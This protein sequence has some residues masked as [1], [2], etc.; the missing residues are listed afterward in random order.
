MSDV[1]SVRATRRIFTRWGEVILSTFLAVFGC[2]AAVSLLGLLF[3]VRRE[4]GL[5]TAARIR[6]IRITRDQQSMIDV[7]SDAHD[8]NREKIE[9]LE[10]SVAER[11]ETIARMIANAGE[12]L[13]EKK[14]SAVRIA[15]LLESLKKERCELIEAKRLA[16]EICAVISPSS[17]VEIPSQ[18]TFQPKRPEDQSQKPTCDN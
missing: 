6:M 3:W 9:N 8:V 13:I 15:C 16:M 2:T 11:D 18:S 10:S 7:M 17:L 4:Y 12:M 14:E 1:A 5:E